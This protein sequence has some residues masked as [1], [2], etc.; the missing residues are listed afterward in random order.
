MYN[1]DVI[2]E[3]VVVPHRVLQKYVVLVFCISL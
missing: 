2:Y 1:H 3:L